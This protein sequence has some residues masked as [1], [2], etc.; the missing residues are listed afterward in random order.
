MAAATIAKAVFILILSLI[1]RFEVCFE[2]LTRLHLSKR[3][4]DPLSLNLEPRENTEGRLRNPR[5]H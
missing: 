5:L 1:K 2:T 3:K 4:V